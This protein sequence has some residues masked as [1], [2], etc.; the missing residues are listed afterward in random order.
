MTVTV[1]TTVDVVVEHCSGG[2]VVLAGGVVLG[3]VVLGGVV[4]GELGNLL[5]VLE[6]GGAGGTV[7]NEGVG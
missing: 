1:I 7:P 3:G 6:D 5:L 4:G 2:V